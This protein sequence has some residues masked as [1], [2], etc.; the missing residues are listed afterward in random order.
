MEKIEKDTSILRIEDRD[1]EIPEL[2]KEAFGEKRK[3]KQNLVLEHVKKS[4]LAGIVEAEEKDL[5]FF[6]PQTQRRQNAIEPIQQKHLAKPWNPTQI[7]GIP[8]IS[9]DAEIW[10]CF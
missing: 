7:S 4:G 10:L 9:A 8:P 3:K 6:L 5:G 2:K 1:P